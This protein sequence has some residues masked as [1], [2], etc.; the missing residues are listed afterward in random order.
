MTTELD[1]STVFSES[2]DAVNQQFVISQNYATAAFAMANSALESLKAEA[3]GLRP[4]DV[5][6]DLQIEEF[7]LEDFIN[8][9]PDPPSWDFQYPPAPTKPTLLTIEPV[10]P[11]GFPEFTAQMMELDIPTLPPVVDPGTPPS[12]PAITDP[13]IPTKPT[14]IM[15]DVPGIILPTMP[16]SANPNFPTWDA[17]PPDASNLVPPEPYITDGGKEFVLIDGL[18]EKIEDMIRGDRPAI[19]NEA[20]DAMVNREAERA[21]QIQNDTIDRIKAEW[22]RKRWPLP[23]GVLVAMVEEAELNYSNKRL[24][25]SK[26]VLIKNLELTQANTHKGIDAGVQLQGLYMNI[27]DAIARRVFEASKALTEA[28]VASYNAGVKKLEITV[29]IYQTRA[30][31]YETIIKAELGKLEVYKAQLDAA[32]LTIDMNDARVKIYQSQ[33]AGVNALIE[34]YRTEMEGA[35]T[36]VEIQRARLDAYRTQIEG[37]VAGINAETAKYSM[38]RAKIEGE[39]SKVEVF[40][41]QADAYKAQVGAKAA[42]LSAK[43]DTLKAYAEANKATASQYAAEV[44]AFKSIIQGE[45]ERINALAKGY[46]AEIEGYKATVD[47]AASFANLEVKVYDARV[48]ALL[49]KANLQI[50]AAEMEIKNYEVEAQLKIESMKGMAQIASSLAIG[51]LTAIHVSAGISGQA[52]VSTGVSYGERLDRSYNYN[53]DMPVPE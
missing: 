13:T 47:G 31:V 48:Q 3:K 1:T 40:S 50:K 19:T 8:D 28:M 42:E 22:S 2:K 39:T 38:Y 33:L 16:E 5:D 15:P 52:Q 37:F 27:A 41:K 25:L 14:V 34:L 36:F 7:K 11:V 24:D 18:K 29:T 43:T 12:P 6:V 26:D 4:I 9:P 17:N 10:Q 30:Q 53:Y 23:N 35:K 21:E 51:A 32:R 46:T 49:G 20:E 44:D 45:A